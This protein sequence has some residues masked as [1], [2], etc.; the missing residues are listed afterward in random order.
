MAKNSKQVA[1]KKVEFKKGELVF[2]KTKGYPNWP[3]L[4]LQVNVIGLSSSYVRVK[5]FNWSPDV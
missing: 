3:A 4:I 2:V 1:I 5:Y